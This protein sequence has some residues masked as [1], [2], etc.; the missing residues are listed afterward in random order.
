[1]GVLDRGWG[2]EE[3]RGRGQR[4][5]RERIRTFLDRIRKGKTGRRDFPCLP[6]CEEV[7]R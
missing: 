3:G 4:N 7:T 2:S 6:L 1:M 5:E